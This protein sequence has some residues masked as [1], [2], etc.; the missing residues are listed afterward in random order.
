MEKENDVKQALVLAAN[1]YAKN[2]TNPLEAFAQLKN[3][4][5]LIDREMKEINKD[6]VL[7]AQLILS[8]EEEPRKS[9]KFQ[10]GGQWFELSLEK[11]IDPVKYPQ[12]YANAD[13]KEY[14]QL[15]A[16][17]AI[18]MDQ[19]SAK[20]KRMNAVKADF[21][22]GHP[23]WKPDA[24]KFTLKMSSEPANYEKASTAATPQEGASEQ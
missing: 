23:D 1:E 24:E 5:D 16:A 12:R 22:A 6:A 20:L 4:A 21:L 18:L 2:P 15:Y 13:G 10:A 11:V 17:R 19:A 9:G 7:Q 3:L 8:K 14:R